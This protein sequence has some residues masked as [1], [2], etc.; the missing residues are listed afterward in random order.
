MRHGPADIHAGAADHRALGHAV[1]LLP[2]ARFDQARRVGEDQARDDR[3]LSRAQLAPHHRT[4]ERRNAR[5][6]PLAPGDLGQDTSVTIRTGA[7][8]APRYPCFRN[9]LLLGFYVFSGLLTTEAEAKLLR[10]TCTYPL[11]ANANGAFGKQE[12]RVEF[13]VDTAGHAVIIKDTGPS[14]VE[15]FAGPDSITFLEKL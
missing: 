3:L 8:M 5:A 1:L 14:E 12:Y 4:Q 6:L 13:D 2:G 11:V 7:A 9:S 10:W 15:L